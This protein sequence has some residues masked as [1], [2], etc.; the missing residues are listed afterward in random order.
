MNDDQILQTADL[1]D[2]CQKLVNSLNLQITHLKNECTVQAKV[3]QQLKTLYSSS[4]SRNVKY[5]D[6]GHLYCKI[7]HKKYNYVNPN[8]QDQ[9]RKSAVVAKDREKDRKLIQEENKLGLS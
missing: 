1:F 9:D 7:Q 5:C 8:V 6:A 4:L 3:I 2:V